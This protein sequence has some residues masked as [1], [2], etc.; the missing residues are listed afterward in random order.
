MQVT[1]TVK[2]GMKK[3]SAAARKMAGKKAAPKSGRGVIKA[4]SKKATPAAKT[5]T[6]ARRKSASTGR[7]TIH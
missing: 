6:R 2:N 3:V 7:R 1:N 4:R 5:Q